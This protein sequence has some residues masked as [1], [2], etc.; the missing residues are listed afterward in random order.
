MIVRTREYDQTLGSTGTHATESTTPEYFHNAWH[1]SSLLSASP[2][3]PP[4]P[5]PSPPPAPTYS[6]NGPKLRGAGVSEVRGHRRRGF[7]PPVL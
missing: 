1:L 7:N 4:L 6:G 2:A 3:A 5:L